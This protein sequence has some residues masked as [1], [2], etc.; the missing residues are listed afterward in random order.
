MTHEECREDTVRPN[1]S[2]LEDEGVKNEVNSEVEEEGVLKSEDPRKIGRDEDREFVR[3]LADPRMPT[4]DE[5]KLHWLQGHYPYRNWCEVC[6][7][8]MGREWD[9]G[10]KI[11]RE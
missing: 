7:K 6:V 9:T 4:E 1:L 2:S 8:A 5:R 11:R 10:W 3:K